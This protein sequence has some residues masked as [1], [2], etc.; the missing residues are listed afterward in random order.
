[1]PRGDSDPLERSLDRLYGLPLEE[2]TASRDALAKELKGSGE[3]DAAARIKKLAKPTRSAGAI[4]RA[5]RGNRRDARRLLTA[6]DKLREAQKQLL[7]KGDR[8]GVDR[9]AEGERAAVG[10]LMAA[11]EQE[12]GRERKATAQALDRARS[13]LHAVA[14][15][16]ELREEF[17]AGRITK[18]HQ[19]VGFGGLDVAPATQAKRQ[20]RTAQR[21][22]VQKR[23]KSA[24][25]DL[26]AAERAWDRAKRERRVAEGR[27]AS[28]EATS[29]RREREVDEAAQALEDAKA[30][31]RDLSEK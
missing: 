26:E 31:L 18:D 4:N 6:A 13:T 7:E 8:R 12:L 27:L 29:S 28:A 2:F 16:P 11:V 20:R 10:K 25:R 19:A 22:E 21:S 24:E 15:S 17:E 14:T 23:V 9:A 1:M 5:V 30:A 3:A